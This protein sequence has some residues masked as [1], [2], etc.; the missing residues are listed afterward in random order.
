[1][2]KELQVKIEHEV[3][4]SEPQDSPA[5]KKMK[6]MQNNKVC[7]SIIDLINKEQGVD[8]KFKKAI[9]P[10][11]FNVK[12]KPEIDNN[13]VQT[14]LQKKID[15]LEKKL[16]FKNLPLNEKIEKEWIQKREKE[17]RNGNV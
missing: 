9:S 4:Y 1:M 16:E 8:K 12:P 2:N 3:K 7:D 17:N 15:K 11:K 10:F 5:V 6:M 13:P 14:S